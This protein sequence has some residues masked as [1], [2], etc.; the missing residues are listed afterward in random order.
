MTVHV[1]VI[2]KSSGVAF[3]FV[4]VDTAVVQ[5]QTK[6]KGNT[7]DDILGATATPDLV[8]AP[9]QQVTINICG[10]DLGKAINAETT[11]ILDDTFFPSSKPAYTAMCGDNPATDEVEGGLKTADYPDLC[12]L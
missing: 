4:L 1:T 3:G 10:S 12:T 2:D 6:S 8:V 5:G 11:I 9:D 7:F